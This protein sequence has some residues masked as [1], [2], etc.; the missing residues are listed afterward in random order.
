MKEGDSG[1]GKAKDEG[2]IA[3]G[4]NRDR[5]AKG[6]ERKKVI[7]KVERTESSS[8]FGTRC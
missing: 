4:R 8:R 1:K 5:K 6:D 2:R 3:S 7:E